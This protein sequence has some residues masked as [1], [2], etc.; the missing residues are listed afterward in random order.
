MWILFAGRY[1]T[2]AD[3]AED[4]ARYVAAGF[5]DA[6]AAFVSDQAAPAG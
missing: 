3:A 5:P 6:E 4:A 2:E 1:D